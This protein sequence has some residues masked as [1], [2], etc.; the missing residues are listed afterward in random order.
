[1]GTVITPESNKGKTIKKIAEYLMEIGLVDEGENINQ[2]LEDGNFEVAGWI[3][4]YIFFGPKGFTPF[5]DS[6]SGTTIYIDPSELPRREQV[7]DFDDP[8]SPAF[9]RAF[10]L[11]ELLI[12]EKYHA[13]Q[14]GWTDRLW[15]LLEIPNFFLFWM[16]RF[17]PMETAAHKHTVSIIDKIIDTKINLAIQVANE[18]PLLAHHI[19]FV[20]KLMDEVEVAFK[21]KYRE[22]S[23]YNSGFRPDIPLGKLNEARQR[24][25]LLILQLPPRISP[26]Q[27][28]NEAVQIMVTLNEFEAEM[29]NS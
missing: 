23:V 27:F 2:Y 14:Q 7:W 6:G 24:F 16:D 9:E 4:R 11:L 18:I 28:T 10:R 3:V 25:Q 22:A 20:K 13:E 1:M 8:T 17:N 5:P 19:D 21:A 12:H 15:Y 29:A 26:A